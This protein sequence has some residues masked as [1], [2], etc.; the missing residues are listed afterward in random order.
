MLQTLSIAIFPA[1]VIVAA[2][3]DVTSFTIPNWISGVLIVA[4]FPAAMIAGLPIA[5]L[6]LHAAVGV[7]ALIAGMA[8][9]AAGWIG[10]GD[11]K[12]FAAAGL[13]LGAQAIAPFILV[14]AL[15]GGL[16]AVVLMNLRSN[17]ARTVIPAGPGWFQRLLAPKGDA[18][19]GVAIAVGALFAFPQAALVALAAG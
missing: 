13:W 18:P 10:G 3:K 2:L 16:L 8:M 1:L 6:G 14:T 9:F 12:L 4:F 5:A 17:W 11:A 15:A 19:Y 7:A